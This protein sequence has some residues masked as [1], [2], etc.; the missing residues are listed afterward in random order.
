MNNCCLYRFI[1]LLLSI[2]VLLGLIGCGGSEGKDSDAVQCHSCGANNDRSAKFCNACG[3]TLVNRGVCPSCGHENSE[4]AAFCSSCGNSLTTQNNG[5]AS[6][7]D[8]SDGNKSDGSDRP[9]KPDPAESIWLQ[10]KRTV[11]NNYSYIVSQYD[12]NG[13]LVAETNYISSTNTVQYTS[14]YTND[15]HGNR[16]SHSYSTPGKT[17]EETY[18]YEYD[19]NGNVIKE[20]YR[21]KTTGPNS[22]GEKEQKHTYDA[23]GQRI[24]TINVQTNQKTVYQYNDAGKLSV[25]KAYDKSGNAISETKY[26]YSENGLLNKK[27][28]TLFGD[29]Y[30][31]TRLIVDNYLYSA[32]GVSTD[33]VRSTDD[34]NRIETTT[35]T[36]LCDKNGNIIQDF[37]Y[38][39]EYMSLA[40]YRKQGLCDDAG[41][42]TCGCAEAGHS[43]CQGHICSECEGSGKLTC[44]SCEGSGK[45]SA[46]EFNGSDACRSCTG[47][48]WW[49]CD[50]CKGSGKWF[51]R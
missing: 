29:E 40:E 34:A 37:Q 14:K 51:S 21:Y 27:E 19:E 5:T 44:T 12:Y 16:L 11:K 26:I 46:G 7:N 22:S 47:T 24:E 43:T 28:L 36:S 38:T 33:V 2:V 8:G 39:Y 13:Y 4:S 25:T 1:A 17:I 31:Y 3:N 32:N 6:G 50:N 48:G 35:Y 10:V 30:N 20:H 18:Q 15:T 9:T 49:I 42:L 41:K 45:D 23:S